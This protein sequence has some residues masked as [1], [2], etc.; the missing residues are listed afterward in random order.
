MSMVMSGHNSLGDFS[1]YAVGSNPLTTMV[2]TILQAEGSASTLAWLRRLDTETRGVSFH[3]VSDDPVHQGLIQAVRSSEGQELLRRVVEDSRWEQPNWIPFTPQATL[4]PDAIREIA[5]DF[6]RWGF[7][8]TL[9]GLAPLSWTVAI[10]D[11]MRRT[12]NG[13]ITVPNYHFPLRG[14]VVVPNTPLWASWTL[15]KQES[16]LG[17]VWMRIASLTGQSRAA[18]MA[19]FER[20]DAILGGV[21]RALSYASGAEVIAQAQRY[22]DDV[23]AARRLFIAQINTIGTALRPAEARQRAPTLYRHYVL[24]RTAFITLDHRVHDM[25]AQVG[26]WPDNESVGEAVVPAYGVINSTPLPATKP[27][28]TKSGFK[29]LEG[30]ATLLIG[31][32]IAAT[33][34]GLLAYIASEITDAISEW[35]AEETTRQSLATAEQIRRDSMR[36]AEMAASDAREAGDHDTASEIIQREAERQIQFSRDLT[37]MQV[38]HSR[39]RQ[40]APASEGWFERIWSQLGFSPTAGILIGGVAVG[41]LILFSSTKGRLTSQ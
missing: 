39:A 23:F 34:I 16:G 26:L 36:L 40:E 3:Q 18:E 20:A 5:T 6:F 15:F 35:R 24:M 13:V 11:A 25:L 38:E 4:S 28:S 33:V 22:H 32:T 37:E 14:V 31:G 1:S 19:A 8:I 27:T 21:E 2:K 7:R 41:G 30:V 10:A 9:R 17:A 12:R 29:G